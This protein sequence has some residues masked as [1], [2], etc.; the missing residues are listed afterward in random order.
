M[1]EP[2]LVTGMPRS[3]TTWIGKMLAAGGAF[4]RV[5]E[6]LNPERPPGRSPGL[7][8]T[9]EHPRFP[10][11]QTHQSVDLGRE[12]QRLASLDYRFRRE[13]A[14]CSGIAD[15]TRACRY[16]AMFWHG[17]RTAKRLLMV[18]PFAS[19]TPGWFARDLGWNVV[20]IVRHPAAVVSSRRRLGWASDLRS[21]LR[22]SGLGDYRDISSFDLRDPIVEG[23][24][25]WN[26]IYDR[27]GREASSDG[28]LTILRYEDFAGAPSTSFADLYDLVGAEF[29]RKV[30]RVIDNATS[31]DNPSQT[32]SDNPH[33]T[34]MYSKAAAG[35]WRAR[36]TMRELE[37]IR[38]I[39]SGTWELFYT[40]DEW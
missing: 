15:T 4:V 38:A 33:V 2:V 27:A 20:M 16:L 26:M 22:Q 39:T 1:T 19:L 8:D 35:A 21:I 24:L 29:S 17:R 36:L 32:A 37:V 7:I 34:R 28:R 11:F 13:L 6:P 31:S 9:G 14:A 40:P 18:D 12:F 5:N 25:L 10:V 3:G 30:A 23:S